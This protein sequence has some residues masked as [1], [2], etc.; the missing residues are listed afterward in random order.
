MARAADERQQSLLQTVVAVV[1][2]LGIGAGGLLFGTAL[3]V[4]TL[5]I[6]Q[7]GVGLNLTTTHIL[8]LGLIFVQGVGCAGVALA[9]VRFRPR[10]ASGIRDLLGI[11]GPFVEFDIPAS[12]PSFRDV[13][14]VVVGYF[15][16]LAAAIGGSL[17][18]SQLAVDTGT[19]S[20]AEVGM[21]NPEII[22]LLIPASLLLVGPGEELLFRGVVQGRIRT[23]FN[24]VVGILVPSVA[25]AGLHWFAL[26]GG[27]TAG[28]LFVVSLLVLPALVFGVSYEYTDNIV[29]PSLIHGFY[30]A[31]LFTGLYFSVVY[32]DQTVQSALLAL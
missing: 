9:Y 3:T 14:V 22:L 7:F 19:N 5:V 25:F 8:V 29:V 11:D 27:S 1:S 6:L 4:L 24:P 17:L 23:V 12:V 13:A 20:A 16:A 18:A 2:A 21:E 26:S 31:T 30:N 15:L 32:A 10:I 28:N